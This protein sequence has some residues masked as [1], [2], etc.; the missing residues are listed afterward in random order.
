MYNFFNHSDF[1]RL[2]SNS[3]GVEPFTVQKISPKPPGSSSTS[4]TTAHL[5][6]GPG[7]DSWLSQHVS[8]YP[9]ILEFLVFLMKS[10]LGP[11]LA[12]K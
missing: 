11:S 6:G 3:S 9:N 4:F 7:H 12:R 8:S 1:N 5:Q 2:Q 10:A